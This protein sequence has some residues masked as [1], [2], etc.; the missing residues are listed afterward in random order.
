MIVE[1]TTDYDRTVR[2]LCEDVSS[3]LEYPQ[4]PIF[5]VETISTLQVYIQ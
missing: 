4:R 2:V 1:V 5:A 3:D